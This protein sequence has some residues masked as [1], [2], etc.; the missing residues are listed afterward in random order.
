[1]VI[2]ICGALRN[3]FES[4]FGKIFGQKLSRSNCLRIQ[5]ITCCDILI[6]LCYFE[7]YSINSWQPNVTSYH[8]PID[9]VH[10]GNQT[11]GMDITKSVDLI[12]ILMIIL[13][14][15]YNHNYL[16]VRRI[17]LFATISLVPTHHIK[18]FM[19]SLR[20]NDIIIKTLKIKGPMHTKNNQCFPINSLIQKSCMLYLNTNVIGFCA[21]PMD[22]SR[23]GA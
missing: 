21:P 12:P 7:T 3:F 19:S 2:N 16:G 13:C 8:A 23:G 20:D 4:M 22:K 18:D 15:N 10:C 11:Y 5:P 1:M 6:F 17:M 14:I 9:G